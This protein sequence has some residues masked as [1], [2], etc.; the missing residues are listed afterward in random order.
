MRWLRPASAPP[1]T[2]DARAVAR[3]LDARGPLDASAWRAAQLV[4]LLIGAD[5]DGGPGGPTADWER[6]TSVR[7]SDLASRAGISIGD[8]AGALRILG[9]AGVLW[10]G[11]TA[12]PA[13]LPDDVSGVVVRVAPECV[14]DG[15]AAAV[16]W[17]PVTA[18]LR[19]SAAGL[20]VARALA[21]AT[22]R[23][24][25]P[26]VVPYGELAAATRYSEG[27]VKRGVAAVLDA[28]AVV[29]HPCRG[30]A[31]AYVFSDWALGRGERAGEPAVSAST[32]MMS[33]APA[34][35]AALA[36]AS[37]APA[38]GTAVLRASLAGVQVE[39][40]AVTGA[41]VVVETVIDGRPV[42]ARLI[43]PATRG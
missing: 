20:L 30:R 29:Q 5:L 32:P 21:G 42:T 25:H 2:V 18:A 34:S 43:I 38:L 33:T 40:P 15:P 41:E 13:P 26:T 17:A 3:W 28:G 24:A 10:S 22:D 1:R 6:G 31:P 8:T 19:G 35:G 9:A 14:T 27:M 4:A 36:A 12:S 23:P 11:E 39:V 37:L 7:V 16:A